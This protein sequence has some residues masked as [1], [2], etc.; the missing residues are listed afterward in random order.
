MIK[1]FKSAGRI[2]TADDIKT[3]A[4]DI[5]QGESKTL[6]GLSENGPSRIIG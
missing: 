3:L 6:L 2:V 1:E 5:D 4:E